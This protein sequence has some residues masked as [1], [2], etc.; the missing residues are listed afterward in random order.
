MRKLIFSYLCCFSLAGYAQDDLMNMLE[1]EVAEEQSNNKVQATFK[2]IKLINANTIE[3]TKKKTME[4]RITHRFGNMQLGKPEAA[5]TLAGL[6]NATNIRFSFDY[7]VTD[8]LS[9]GVGRSKT[10]EHIDGNLKYRFLSQKEQG[11]PLSVAYF[12][13]VAL[14]PMKNW[15]DG[16]LDEFTNRLSYTHQLII[17]R[18][19]G[20]RLSLEVLPT[21][22]HRNF[23]DQ[24]TPHPENNSVDENDL[25]AIGFAGRIKLTQRFSLVADY[26]LTLSDY[27][28]ATNG[29]YDPVGIGVE[30]ETG[31]HVFHIN[32]TNSAGI[33]EN[34]YLPY[35]TSSWGAGEY[36]LGFNIS[37]V[38][39]F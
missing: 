20:D 9:I 11:M 31:G 32:V 33:I 34:D 21:I 22:V 1:E 12:T 28:T 25:I 36:K 13:N 38:F 30:I 23:V 7:G 37:R 24:Q 18:K 17:A 15:E 39:N 8:N 5:H 19:F 16:P 3:T 4:F 6:D 26:F 10:F 2:G 27:R 14:T 35:S 29:F